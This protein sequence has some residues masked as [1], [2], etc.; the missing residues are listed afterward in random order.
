LITLAVLASAESEKLITREKLEA[1]KEVAK[2]DVFDYEDHPFKDLT[3]EEVIQKSGVMT[4]KNH[5]LRTI[6]YGEPTQALP[7]SFHYKDKW[8]QCVHP[9]RDQQQCGSCWAFA[10]SEV[11]SDRMCIAT[12]GRVNVVMSP[13]DMVSCDYGALGCQGGYVDQSWSY[14][15]SYGIVA[16]S[17]LPYTSGT[18]NRGYCPFYYGKSCVYGTYKKYRVSSYQQYYTIASAKEAIY[19]E[20]PIEA[21]FDLYD[22]GY[23]Y[24]GGVYRRASNT[25]I[26]PHAVKLVGWGVDSYG[27]EYWIIANSWN[28]NW[29]EQGYM[30]IAFGECGIENT[31]WAGR[32]LIE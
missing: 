3:K 2:F 22:D 19:N 12:E 31:L 10:A 6:L 1:L 26:G 18:G 16:D 24:R 14:I 28:T 17:C 8:P 25:L 32:P 29:G 20:G 21:V 15:Q 13:Q 11:L 4:N 27:Y 5:N 30:K 9:I 23:S 7:R